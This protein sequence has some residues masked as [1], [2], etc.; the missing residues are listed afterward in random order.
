MP[1]DRSQ[2][3]GFGYAQTPYRVE[4][5]PRFAPHT[6]DHLTAVLDALV[7]CGVKAWWYSV[8][9]KGSYPLFASKHLPYREEVA[10][11][12]YP[13]LADEAHKRDIA[14]FS[15]EYLSTAPLLTAQHPDWRF[16]Y[17]GWDGPYS[18]RDTHFVCYNS[19]YG[20]LL[21]DYCVEV[22][23]DLG[24][25]GIWFDGSYVCSPAPMKVACACEFCAAKYRDE[26]G[27]EL[28]SKVDMTDMA[29]RRYLEW[30]YEDFTAYWRAL[31]AHVHE[32]QPRAII[33]FNY[34]NRLYHGWHTASPLRRMPM[35]G[36][37]ATECDS[38]PRL[39]HKVLHALNDN[40]PT[41][42]WIGAL[43][44]TGNT[45]SQRPDPEP[46]SLIFHG[47]LSAA[48]GGYASFGMG[49]PTEYRHTLTALTRALT[50]IAEYVGGEPVRLVGLVLSG[51]TKDYAYAD[52]PVDKWQTNPALN[53]PHFAYEAYR[54]QDIR[55][56]QSVV[57]M[58]NLLESLH[59]PTDVL[60][61]NMLTDEHLSR[62]QAVVLPDVQCM[63]D[64]TAGAL[65]RY[66][67]QGGRL[68]ALGDTGVKTLMGEP[69][70]RGALDD[71]FG[72]TWRDDAS[73]YP[74]M[75]VHSPLLTGDGL[76]ERYA[77]GGPARL[78][79]AEGVDVLATATYQ[80]G[81]YTKVWS[82]SGLVPST[83]S[84]VAGA[85]IVAVR[86]GK[87][88]AVYLAQNVGLGYAPNPN[89]RSREVIR[90]LLLPWIDPPFQTDAPPSVIVKPWRQPGR[91]VFHLLNMPA[92]MLELRSDVYQEGM[93]RPEDFTPVGPIRISV[94]GPYEQASSPTHPD[95]VRFD[96]QDGAI[97]ISL[98]RLDQHAVV[99]VS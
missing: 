7:Q 52:D 35:E 5:R 25:D 70:E 77:I 49:C 79:R 74:V 15:W 65:G 55:C 58:D 83:A 2:L 99:V 50:P 36:M 3:D 38:Q 22:V 23:S 19:P 27:R 51:A 75:D 6:R 43:D 14:L 21:K 17:I 12:I 24:L 68:V 98:G 93:T 69:R 34:F 89:R 11:D 92:T 57:G 37:I 59:L 95:Q 4:W 88:H 30:R 26:T 44:G 33:V 71:L 29:F 73:V 39:Q 42:V 13:W 96:R 28:P 60:L 81:K 87:G 8:S 10:T 67:E 66:V 45:P 41:E 86:R 32:R 80:P 20:D 16:R 53:W 63:S 94:P 84:E 97:E 90:R 62:Y 76:P 9:A 82:S 18:D 61:D 1:Q 72:I 85:A 40:Y 56:W 48:M 78:V 46:T 54:S 64:D 31:S 47:Q 91:L